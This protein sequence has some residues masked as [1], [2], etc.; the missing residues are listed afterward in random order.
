VIVLLAGLVSLG[1][2]V[3]VSAQTLSWAVVPSPSIKGDDNFLAAVSCT[4]AAFCEAVGAL[5]AKHATSPLI[6]SWNGKRWAT[7]TTP[8]APGGQLDAVSCVSATACVAVGFG[9]GPLAER[10][11]GTRWSI[12][13]TPADPN[14][15]LAGVSCISASACT[16]VGSDNSGP[17]IESWNGTRWTIVPSPGKTLDLLAGVS[18]VS[19]AFCAAVGQSG[20]DGSGPF[21][22]SWNGTRWSVVPSPHKP[23]GYLNGVSCVSAARCTAV[24]TYLGPTVT[25]KPLA[26]SWNGTRWTITPIPT[27]KSDDFELNGVSCLSA[28]RCTAAG[29][30]STPTSPLR[31]LIE[32][33]N[34][35]RWSR[36]ASPS[37]TPQDYV[38][39][40]VSCPSARTCTAAGIV[41]PPTAELSRTVIETGTAGT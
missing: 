4:S 13:P 34:G 24:G 35:T 30:W 26:E 19:P 39:F 14:G 32:S 18:C 1:A 16:A 36:V 27:P 21:I 40:G 6:D 28:A 23:T 8:A 31:T 7:A 37:P 22:E 5:T 15:E 17:S 12:M 2:L 29:A 20:P 38:L 41:T 25:G 33:W 3:P 10:W 9:V 11:N